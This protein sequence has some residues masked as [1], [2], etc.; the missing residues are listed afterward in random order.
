VICTSPRS[1]SSLL[2]EGL[3]NTGRAGAP[4]EYFDDRREFSEYW[5]RQFG[6]PNTVHY[7]DGVVVHSSTANGFFGAKLHWTNCRALRRALHASVGSKLA[8]VRGRSLNELLQAKFASIQY[9]WL[10]RRNKVAQGISHYLAIC[11]DLWQISRNEWN[12]RAP[13]NRQSV[14][15]D[16]SMIEDCVGWASGYDAEWQGFFDRH[17]LRPLILYYEEFAQIYDRTIRD[18]LDF[19]C[20]P[21]GDVVSQEPPLVRVANPRSLE[22]EERYVRLKQAGER[23]PFAKSSNVAD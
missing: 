18:V 4:A 22:W 21:H 23:R 10:R 13:D 19:L 6:I 11:T 16:L 14:D 12:Q 5:R 17:K 7:F 1:G 9:V 20:V 3:K 15:F 8:D 2:C